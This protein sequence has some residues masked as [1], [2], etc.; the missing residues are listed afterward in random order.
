[1]PSADD[2]L[3]SS[4][5]ETIPPRWLNAGAS[6]DGNDNVYF[7]NSEWSGYDFYNP[8]WS[9]YGFVLRHDGAEFLRGSWRSPVHYRHLVE[10]WW[11]YGDGRGPP[12]KAEARPPSRLDIAGGVVAFLGVMMLV[13]LWPRLVVRL[14]V[15]PKVDNV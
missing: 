3:I 1:M 8:E 2:K 9:G 11:F 14:L 5:L 7:Y 13:G 15:E 6:K 12:A 10:D 4:V